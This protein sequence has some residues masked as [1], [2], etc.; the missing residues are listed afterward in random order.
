MLLYE[1]KLLDFM[2]DY[3]L[4]ENINRDA[5]TEEVN[6]IDLSKMNPKKYIRGYEY[7]DKGEIISKY[8]N[9]KPKTIKNGY[10][11]FTLSQTGLVLISEYFNSGTYES[12]AAIYLYNSKNKKLEKI[13][14]YSDGDDYTEI[15]FEYNKDTVKIVVRKFEELD[16][17]YTRD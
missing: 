14:E 13:I 5:Y 8:K 6:I 9:G 2:W 17:N 7:I 10:W 12:G 1:K 4:G 11:S 3:S 15:T 16:Y